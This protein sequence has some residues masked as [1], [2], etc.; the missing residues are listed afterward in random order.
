MK[1]Y[2]SSTLP[3]NVNFNSHNR[4]LSP[5]IPSYREGKQLNQRT[6]LN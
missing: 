6:K 3:S 4:Y 2:E 5:E 1:L